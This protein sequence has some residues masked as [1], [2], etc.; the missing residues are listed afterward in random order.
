MDGVIKGF[1]IYQMTGSSV[2]LGLVTMAAG[3]PLIIG[4][5]YG[6]IL[7]DRVDRMKLLLI[8]QAAAMSFAAVMTALLA[9]GAIQFWHFIVL[10]A[11]GGT[12]FAFVAPLRQSIIARLVSPNHLMSAVA[13]N[14][15]GFNIMGILG[16][17]LVGLLLTIMPPYQTY[18]IIV[19]C[20][21]AGAVMLAF[22]RLP[23]DG[24][25]AAGPFHLELAEGF[26]FILGNRPI[27]GFLLVA[28]VSSLF[29]VPNSLLMPA[30]ASA[31]LKVDQVGFG[32]LCA[33]RALGASTGS[34][35]TA[36]L[37][38][39]KNKGALVLIFLIIYGIFSALSA[40]FQSFP[41]ALLLVLGAG[42][43]GTIYITLCNTL[44]LTNTPASMHGRIISI[45]TMA[46]GLTP[47]G[48]LPMGAL[49]DSIGLPVTFLMAGA[50]A[51]VFA[52]IMWF[53]IPS[54]RKV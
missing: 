39:L 12:T 54:M 26:R 3:V 8:T 1:L 44:I 21:L 33:A 2:N 41:P 10:A 46:A 47:I 42:L 32:F 38:Q 37:N 13:L 50:V 15:A 24:R 35:V 28:L 51:V 18:L 11:L 23:G 48:T 27:L 31:V 45:Y 4:S 19:G 36:S 9:A 40:Q 25:R 6:G 20:F 34:L 17:A 16:P 29:V 7:A 49:A 30:L 5:I 14:S 53:S 52:V 22:I 43:T